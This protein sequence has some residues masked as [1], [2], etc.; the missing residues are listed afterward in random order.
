MEEVERFTAR[1][2]DGQLYT[3]VLLA[4]VTEFKPLNGPVQRTLGGQTYQLLDG[5]HVNRKDA[6]TF[7]IFDT[8]EVIVRID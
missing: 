4:T 3:V 7:E 8:D 1:G 2:T 6:R 5:S